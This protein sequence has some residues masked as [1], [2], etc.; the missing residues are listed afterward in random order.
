VGGTAVKT[1]NSTQ[2]TVSRSSG[3]AELYALVKAASEG[4]G[5]VA[6]LSELGRKVQL[7]VHCDSSAAIGIANRSGLGKCRHLDVQLLWIQGAIRGGGVRLFKCP[8]LLNPADLLTKVMG[9][10]DIAPKLELVGGFY[11]GDLEYSQVVGGCWNVAPT[12]GIA[13][14]RALAAKYRTAD[15]STSYAPTRQVGLVGGPIL[16][17]RRESADSAPCTALA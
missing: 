2:Q 14:H 4:L 16:R 13:V 6:L 8:G 12:I 1:W 5:M 15:G 11:L 9:R 17:A 3:E 10:A 7:R